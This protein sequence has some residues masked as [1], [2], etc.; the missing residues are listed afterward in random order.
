[1]GLIGSKVYGVTAEF[2]STHPVRGGT[3]RLCPAVI[4][5]PI[6]IHP[7]REGWDNQRPPMSGATR[8]FQSTHPVRGGTE[9]L[10]E[11]DFGVFISIHPPREGWD[12]DYRRRIKSAVISIH[13]PREGWDL[14]LLAGLGLEN[15]ISIHPPREGW[16]APCVGSLERVFR[17]FNPPTP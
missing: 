3:Y 6:S 2:Q 17:N 13:P 1:M 4:L 15:L 14:D 7:P 8:T 5:F 10:H 12:F 9:R 11:S 16:D